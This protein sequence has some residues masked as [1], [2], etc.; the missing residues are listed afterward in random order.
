MSKTEFKCEKECP[1]RA[2]YEKNPKSLIGR[3]WHW[4][5][6]FCPGWK[7]YF[8]SRTPQEQQALREKYNLKK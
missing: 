1:L 6:G 3:F 8:Q 7:A 2:R 4:H 5:T